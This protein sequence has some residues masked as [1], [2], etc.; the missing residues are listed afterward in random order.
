MTEIPK[1]SG[2][3]APYLDRYLEKKW[4]NQLRQV[5]ELLSK[6]P[7]LTREAALL[8]SFREQ[9]GKEGKSPSPLIVALRAVQMQLA[10]DDAKGLLGSSMIERAAETKQ[11]LL[12][13]AYRS[14]QA[15]DCFES[16]PNLNAVGNAINQF[17][18]LSLVYEA[19]LN[20]NSAKL[21]DE[22]GNIK[23]DDLLGFGKFKEAF[24]SSWWFREEDKEF[25][26]FCERIF[27]LATGA[28]AKKQITT[29][30]YISV[31]VWL[32][33]PDLL[34]HE[35][36]PAKL[37]VEFYCRLLRAH[38]PSQALYRGI[39]PRPKLKNFPAGTEPFMRLNEGRISWN[40]SNDVVFM[41]RNMV[42]TD[43]QTKDGITHKLLF[44]YDAKTG[45]IKEADDSLR[46]RY[47][48]RRTHR[49]GTNEPANLDFRAV[50][51][52]FNTE[53][54]ALPKVE[55]REGFTDLVAVCAFAS[56][57][58]TLLTEE[59]ISGFEQVIAG[60]LPLC[61][62]VGSGRWNCGACRQF[63]DAVFTH[64]LTCRAPRPEPVIAE[65]KRPTLLGAGTVVETS[66]PYSIPTTG[67]GAGTQNPYGPGGYTTQSRTAGPHFLP[68]WTCS[69]CTFE[70][71]G[72]RTICDICGSRRHTD[73]WHSVPQSYR[74]ES[75]ALIPSG[76]AVAA[77]G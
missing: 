33:D 31:L 65:V 63:N 73:Y 27:F 5:K 58:V 47:T 51:T 1:V 30:E 62:K 61:V 42:L 50:L 70:N 66:P 16:D 11:T 41:H 35:A 36:I 55:K 43:P 56:I 68:T 34:A 39:V 76:Y 38:T 26:V 20:L 32:G 75:P 46:T 57:T 21:L 24:R 64:C 52:Q 19:L 14:M 44:A 29:M 53:K 45:V 49:G 69:R 59:K 40:A 12:V 48:R 67:Y 4:P 9:V 25:D 28:G 17:Y 8:A 37:A 22:K 13:D 60:F 54:R 71:A 7:T 3:V 77:C 2:S 10:A 18:T 15:N 72:A 6:E 23:L 74:V